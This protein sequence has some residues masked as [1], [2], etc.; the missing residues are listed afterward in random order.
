M[1]E[2]LRSMFPAG[3]AVAAGLEGDPEQLPEDERRAIARAIPKRALEFA[4]GRACARA[5]LA[6]LGVEVPAIPVAPNRAPIWPAGVVGSITHCD[7]FVA[8]A[9]AR[10]STVAGLG[11]D[12]E[13]AQP[14]LDPGVRRLVC[15]EREVAR[16][17]D[18]PSNPGADWA[19]VV[20][21]AKEAV[22]KVVSPRAGITLG[23]HDVE[24]EIDARAGT[25]Q[26]RP[27]KVLELGRVDLTRLEGRFVV[28]ES[29]ILTTLV[30][31][32]A[33]SADS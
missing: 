9:V 29:H 7:G 5:A 6:E 26:V 10:G 27:A 33:A 21:S 19:R 25:F 17:D 32:R 20:F 28:T 11:V 1:L 31:P 16:F 30:L 23:F 18:L 8:A 22:H 2:L 24:L 15:T 13:T 14:P 3:V 4:R 12:A